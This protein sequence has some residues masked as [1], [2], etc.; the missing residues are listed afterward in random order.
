MG[1]GRFD[2]LTLLICEEVRSSCYDYHD[3]KIHIPSKTAGAPNPGMRRYGNEAVLGGELM[4]IEK[5]GEVG[6]AGTGL[7]VGKDVDV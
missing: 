6:D 4:K 7:D 2:L 5:I 3:P 1:T